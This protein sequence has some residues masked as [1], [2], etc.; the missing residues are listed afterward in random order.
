MTMRWTL[1]LLLTLSICTALNVH[2]DNPRIL[3]E[4][5]EPFYYQGDTAWTFF[6]DLTEAEA[7]QYLDERKARGFNVIQI[8]GTVDWTGNGI[9]ETIANV[10]GERP[11]IDD[12]PEDFNPAFWNRVKR[13]LDMVDERDMYAAIAVGTC[14]RDDKIYF[15]GYDDHEKA[16]RTGYSWGETLRDYND[17]IIWVGGQDMN[18]EVDEKNN[19]LINIRAQMEGIADAVNGVPSNYNQNADYS[20]TFM[21]YH[22]PGGKQSSDYFHQDPW[23]D[24]NWIQTYGHLD[25][26]PGEIRTDYAKTPIKP[27]ML[28]E[29]AYEDTHPAI[30]GDPIEDAYVN[31][32]K[33]Y[34]HWVPTAGAYRYYSDEYGRILPWH[35][36]Y[37]AYQTV[38][39]GAAGIGYGHR[40]H[41]QTLDYDWSRTKAREAEGAW[42]LKHLK[43]LVS[44][45]MLELMPDN[46]LIASEPSSYA[47]IE[48]NMVI[49]ART[50]EVAFIYTTRG[51]SFTADLTRI[52]G[53]RVRARWYDPRTG[54]YTAVGEY[55]ESERL[56]DPPGSIA[57][58]N[59]WVLVLEAVYD[60]P[61]ECGDGNC[62]SGEDCDSCPGDCPT[63]VS[64]VCCSG[65]IYTGD[66]CSIDDCGEHEDCISHK[67]TIQPYCGDGDCNGDDDCSNCPGDCPT[68][69]GQVCCSG[70]LYAGE[71]CTPSDCDPL[72]CIGH[73]CKEGPDVC[74]GLLLLLH[75][76]E[77]A[78]SVSDALGRYHGDVIGASYAVGKFG[79][80]YEFDSSSDKIDLG[81][82]LDFTDGQDMTITGWFNR[83]TFTTEDVIIA[84]RARTGGFE[85]AGYLLYIDD[86]GDNLRFRVCDGNDEYG[87]YG[88]T[89]FTSSGWHFF[90][91]VLDE[92][93]ADGTKVYIDGLDDTASTEWS[94]PPVGDLTNSVHL[95]IGATG[96]NV[97]PFPGTIDEIAIWDRA[98]SPE[99]IET[100][101]S[102]GA[103]T[104]FICGPA[105]VNSDDEIDMQE[106]I[107]FITEWKVGQV[108]LDDIVDAIAAWLG[109]C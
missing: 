73:V 98:L 28:A 105:D 64:Q 80:A 10:E 3:A 16:Y 21:T 14:L 8:F 86:N 84:K 103:I 55:S 12:N 11:F 26:A 31:P 85:N 63:G 43:D 41:I 57:D 27:T 81:D 22:P 93:S 79:G 76:D 87:T 54:D 5:T 67:C 99:E 106:L 17:L 72:Q 42:D 39:S 68:G 1:V 59:D 6:Y 2:P 15:I 96:S 65:N 58:S 82:V 51:R 46:Y 38:F 9:T 107:D 95:E 97:A 56:F 50:D 44:P 62:D 108:E 25:K 78:S 47:N 24:F 109:G 19:L 48:T 60:D 23:L 90:A 4:G 20:T 70:D 45:H 69:T 7:E 33:R 37:Q 89:K 100:V 102:M 40:G 77:D 30:P 83:K 66:C 61:A 75:M 49:G 104:C 88:G 91:A 36:R 32:N 13:L 74:D 29:G 34:R 18:I 92:D 94:L 71:C 53:D 35:N 101:Y 52:N